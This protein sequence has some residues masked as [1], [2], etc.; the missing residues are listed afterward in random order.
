M[1]L[2]IIDHIGFEAVRQKLIDGR[3][4]DGGLR[5]WLGSTFDANEIDFRTGLMSYLAIS[6]RKSGTLLA[7]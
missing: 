5:L 6:A 3:N 2:R 7:D 4:C 1:L